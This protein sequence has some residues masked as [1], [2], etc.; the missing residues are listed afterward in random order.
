MTVMFNF[1]Y[2]HLAYVMELETKITGYTQL[3]GEFLECRN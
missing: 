1:G 2:W 3:S